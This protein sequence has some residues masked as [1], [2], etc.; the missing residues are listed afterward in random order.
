MNWKTRRWLWMACA[1][2]ILIFNGCGGGGSGGT[3]N[4][5]PSNTRVATINVVDSQTKANIPNLNLVFYIGNVQFSFK[6]V[7]SS[8]TNPSRQILLDAARVLNPNA[9]LGDYIISDLPVSGTFQ[10]IWVQRPAGYTAIAVHRDPKTNNTTRVVQIPDS[11]VTSVGCL[12]ATNRFPSDFQPGVI[13]NLGTVELYPSNST[14]PPPPPDA[15]C[16]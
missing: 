2:A 11:P 15:N 5:T 3:N 12:L 7:V 8:L 4:V 14:T 1:P 9:K 13:A 6:Q 16:P 10:G